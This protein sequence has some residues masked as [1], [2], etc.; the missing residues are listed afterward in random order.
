MGRL[1]GRQRSFRD[2]LPGVGLAAIAVGNA[3]ALEAPAAA[4]IQAA[5]RHLLCAYRTAVEAC[6]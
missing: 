4:S 3:V 5:G 2:G 6:Y 1:E